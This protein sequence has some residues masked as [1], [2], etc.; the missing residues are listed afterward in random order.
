MHTHIVQKNKKRGFGLIEIIVGSSILGTVM[1]SAVFA[2]NVIRKIE[3]NT[4]NIVRANYLL[5]ETVDIAK[6]LRDNSWTTNIAPLTLNTPYYLVWD[7]GAWEATTDVSIIDGRFYRTISFDAVNRDA[8]SADI[9]TT[10]GL[11]DTGTRLITASVA[12]FNRSGTT[13]KTFKT[14]MM[15]LHAN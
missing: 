11:N 7:S 9:V 2:I 1:I 3:T 13:T 15:D 14:Y 10:G 8:G 5:L 6:I 12:W 4:A